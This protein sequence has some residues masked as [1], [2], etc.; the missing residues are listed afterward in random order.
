MPWSTLA[1]V[2]TPG[3]DRS[4][5]NGLRMLVGPGGDYAER[6]IRI[7]GQGREPSAAALAALDWPRTKGIG[8]ARTFSEIR[9]VN[10]DRLRRTARDQLRPSDEYRQPSDAE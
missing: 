1:P 10:R 9:W 3:R 8:V 4:L 5:L 7:N 2:I 6:E